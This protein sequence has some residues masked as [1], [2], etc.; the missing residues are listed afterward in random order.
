MTP[1]VVVFKDTEGWFTWTR[2]QWWDDPRHLLDGQRIDT[3]EEI[4]RVVT[5]DEAYDIINTYNQMVHGRTEKYP[6]R[7]YPT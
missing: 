2:A 4:S 7:R 3:R 1:D 5:V 6:S